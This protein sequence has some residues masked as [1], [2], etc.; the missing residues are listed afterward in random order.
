MSDLFINRF[1]FRGIH[2]F[3]TLGSALRLN[4]KPVIYKSAKLE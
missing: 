3:A 4:L 1:D 2:V